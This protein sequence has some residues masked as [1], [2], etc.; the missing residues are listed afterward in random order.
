VSELFGDEDRLNRTAG[1]PAFLA[2]E[3]VSG[4]DYRGQCAP[5]GIALHR[6]TLQLLFHA[7]HT[8]A[9]RA[10]LRVNDDR[11]G[12]VFITSAALVA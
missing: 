3:V 8:S 11:R 12:S 2:P 4:G 6:L 1:T 9:K 7:K 10:E 5:P